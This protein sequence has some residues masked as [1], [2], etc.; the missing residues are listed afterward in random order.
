MHFKQVAINNYFNVIQ[1][2]FITFAISCYTTDTVPKILMV[3]REHTEYRK[4]NL[5]LLL[6]RSHVLNL[7]V[8]PSKMLKL[9]KWNWQYWS[10]GLFLIERGASGGPQRE[11]SVT[12]IM[13]TGSKAYLGYTRRRVVFCNIEGPD[14]KD[15]RM[16]M[17][18]GCGNSHSRVG[19]E[20]A[21]P[22]PPQIC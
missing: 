8:L 22:P 2:C 11:H 4:K 1:V 19:R 3:C 20:T 21:P 17:A 13:K 9:Y 18:N 15:K 6:G 10:E 14:H 12:P 7:A 5:L 16:L